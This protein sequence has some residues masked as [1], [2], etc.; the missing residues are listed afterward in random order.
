MRQLRDVVALLVLN[1]DRRERMAMLLVCITLVV[2]VSGDEQSMRKVGFSD[3]SVWK[4]GLSLPV[5]H[6]LESENPTFLMTAP[7]EKPSL[8][9][10][11]T[12]ELKH[13]LFLVTYTCL[14]VQLAKWLNV[15]LDCNLIIP[16]N[17][18]SFSSHNCTHTAKAKC[19]L[20]LFQLVTGIAPLTA[21]SGIFDRLI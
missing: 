12:S 10:Q 4:T 19:K 11:S 6:T 7:A 9:E 2:V 15:T 8:N 14:A 21:I 20:Q 5:F 16:S 18:G 13:F 17:T 3:S 1:S